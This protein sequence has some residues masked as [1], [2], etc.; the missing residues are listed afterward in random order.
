MTTT[1][2]R[3]PQT[4]TDFNT[5]IDGIGFAGVVNKATI[6]EII[7]KTLEKDLT[8]S[9]GAYDILTGAIEKLES[10]VE[11]DTFSG[12]SIFDLVG[13]EDAADVAVIFRGSLKDGAKDIALKVTFQGIW[14]SV[15]LSD[16]EKGSEVKSSY[17]VSLR[18][19]VI[20]VDDKEVVYINLPTWEIRMNGKDRSSKI[21]NNLGL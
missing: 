21:K 20:E 18:K 11:L 12:E 4:L 8:G 17:K 6:P 10:T 1:K 7:F 19:L 9:A 2:T 16:L 14:K 5:F 3:Y 15:D 13:S